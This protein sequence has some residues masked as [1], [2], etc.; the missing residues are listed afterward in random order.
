[1][2]KDVKTISRLELYKRVWETPLTRLAKEYGLSDVSPIS[3][4]IIPFGKKCLRNR[5]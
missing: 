1:M 3:L 4:E 5:R 2:S